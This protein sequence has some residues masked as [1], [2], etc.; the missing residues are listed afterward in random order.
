MWETPQ[1]RPV[2]HSRQIAKNLPG[3]IKM[4]FHS[5]TCLGLSSLFEVA[6]D[7]GTIGHI[8][9]LAIPLCRPEIKY[10]LGFASV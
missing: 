4:I 7:V 2:F 5:E 3:V 8:F 6:S 9:R 10:K 1:L